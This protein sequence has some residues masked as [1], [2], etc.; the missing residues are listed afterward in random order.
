MI[1]LISV[2]I[3]TILAVI[4]PGAD[5]AMITRNSYLYGRRCGLFS[6]I[7]IAL[8]V[9]VH[10][11][12]TVMGVG[13]VLSQSHHV[14]LTL[15]II[16]AIYLVYIGYKTFTSYVHVDIE[17][18]NISEM[19]P[20]MALRMGFMTNALNP[21]TMLFVVSTYTQ[22]VTADTRLLMQIIYGGFMSVAHW[23]WFSLVALFFS[24]PA[25]R[26][27]MVQKQRVLNKIIG[28]VLIALGVSLAGVPILS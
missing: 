5:F 9:L 11:A 13:L 12:Y 25:L 4:S 26:A 2:A 1:E 8:G 28:G 22:V 20:L 27:A 15:K 19:S 10:V 16:G 17:Q 24:H 18:Q 21:K 7:G 14:F 6:A 23:A 3:I